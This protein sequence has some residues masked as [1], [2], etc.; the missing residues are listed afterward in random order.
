[1]Q[2]SEELRQIFTF[3]HLGKVHIYFVQ[4]EQNSAPALPPPQDALDLKAELGMPQNAVWRRFFTDGVVFGDHWRDYKLV[5]FGML[6]V[7]TDYDPSGLYW[8]ITDIDG[9]PIENIQLWYQKVSHPLTPVSCEFRWHPEKGEKVIFP[10][11]ENAK[12]ER[13]L[14]IAWRG[15]ALL[16]KVARLGRP[17]NSFNL[18]EF[19]FMER[20]QKAFINWVSNFGEEPTDVQLAEELGIS[21]A[22]FYRYLR[23]YNLTIHQIRA[24]GRESII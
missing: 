19:E 18:S 21:R 22:T 14:T 16:R 11:M 8:Q 4:S 5:F 10:G 2:G 3:S 7:D 15:K 23:N 1:M 20:A 13:D 12:R 9:N 6:A 17:A 24:K